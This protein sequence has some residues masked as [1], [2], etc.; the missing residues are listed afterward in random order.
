MDQ[1]AKQK[2][3]FCNLVQLLIYRSTKGDFIQVLHRNSTNKHP[4]TIIV[5]FI[6]RIP[7]HFWQYFKEK[8]ELV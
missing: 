3:A 4:I 8:L 7:F 5:F 2:K 1:T 6:K